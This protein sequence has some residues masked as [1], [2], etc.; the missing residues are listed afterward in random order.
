MTVSVPLRIG[1]VVCSTFEEERRERG[2]GRGKKR[3]GRGERRRERI[4][5]KR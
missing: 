5:G 1:V 4:R 3:E 2:E